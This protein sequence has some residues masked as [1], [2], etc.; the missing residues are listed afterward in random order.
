MLLDS[1]I[2]FNT[3]YNKDVYIQETLCVC[4]SL[5]SSATNHWPTY[6]CWVYYWLFINVQTKAAQC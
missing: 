6:C 5:Q 2:V 3:S 1:T 4:F